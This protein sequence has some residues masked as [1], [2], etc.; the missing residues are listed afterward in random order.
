[1][2]KIQIDLSEIE[3]KTVDVYKLVNNL[4]TKE[5]AIKQMIKYFKVKIEPKHIAKNEEYYKKATKFSEDEK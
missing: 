4:R 5:E 3:N 2:V 1:M